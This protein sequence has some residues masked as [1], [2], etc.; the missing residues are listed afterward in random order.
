MTGRIAAPLVAAAMV[1]LLPLAGRAQDFYRSKTVTILVSTSPGGGFDANGRLLARHLGAYIAGKPQ[2]I[3]QNMPGAGGGTAVRYLDNGAAK[4]GTVITVFNVGLIGDSLLAPQRTKIDFR[5]YAW[6]GS[7]AENLAVCYLWHSVGPE[8]IA[9]MR[10]R[11][12]LNFGSTGAGGGAAYMNIMI[13]KNVFGI[14]IHLVSG[15][16]GSAEYDLAI[17]RGELDGGCDSW[18]SIPESW[19]AEGKIVPIFRAGTSQ[20]PDMKPG[21]PILDEIA[22]DARARAIVHLLNAANELGRP[23][24]ASRAVPAERIAILRRAF[25]Q[26]VHDPEFVAEAAKARL[27]VSPRSGTQALQIVEQIYA[28]PPDIVAAARKV[29]EE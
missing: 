3:V 21:V 2:V 22:P 16:P 15:Y 5:D 13:L 28:T 29:I 25:E 26:A 10:A 18:S 17:E 11:G 8:N 24:V 23:F 14:G 1:M 6:I 4:D 19:I 12:R 20:P 7:I 9:D 27:P